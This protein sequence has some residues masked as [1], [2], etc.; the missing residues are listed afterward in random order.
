M[1]RVRLQRVWI[2]WRPLGTFWRV[3]MGVLDC[4]LKD[5]CISG[6]IHSIQLWCWYFWKAGPKEKTPRTEGGG[7]GGGVAFLG[8]IREGEPRQRGTFSCKE[9]GRKP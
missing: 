1:V 3:L 8:F 5:G 7:T 6:W 9:L 2:V 4:G